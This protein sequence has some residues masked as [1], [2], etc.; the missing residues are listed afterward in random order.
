MD[1]FFANI[2]NEDLHNYKKSF[3]FATNNSNLLYKQ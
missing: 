2:T 3:I 1:S